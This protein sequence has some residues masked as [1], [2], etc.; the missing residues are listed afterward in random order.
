MEVNFRPIITTATQAHFF[1]GKSLFSSMRSPTSAIREDLHTLTDSAFQAYFLAG[2]SRTFALTIPQLPESV[3][4]VIANGYLL[5]RIVDTIED[6]ATLDRNTKRHFCERF[7]AVV[8]GR[9][10]A[11]L[12]SQDFAARLSDRTP[13][14][15]QELIRAIPRVIAITHGFSHADIEALAR[16]V[17]I[18]SHGMAEFQERDLRCGLATLMDLNRYCYY[19][20]G[21]VGE[22]LTQVF[23]NHFAPLARLKERMLELAVSFGQGLQMTNILKDVW[24]DLERGVCWLPRDIFEAHGYDLCNLHPGHQNPAFAAGLRDLIA[25]AHGHLHNAL[26]YT[27]LIPKYETGLRD[28]CLWALGMA[29]LTLRKIDR[30]PYFSRSAEVKISRRSVKVVVLTTRLGHRHDGL[31]RWLFNIASRG[32]PGPAPIEQLALSRPPQIAAQ[33]LSL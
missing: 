27:L 9:E 11:S 14:A 19:V 12:F 18:M 17:A 13:P 10:D 23:C 30:H 2:V 15:E 6:E 16:C 3:H 7:V 32:L 4:Q 22:M 8:Q 21:V 1:V 24:D 20:A 28:F 31:L 25:I 29:I 33:S 26:E 5:C